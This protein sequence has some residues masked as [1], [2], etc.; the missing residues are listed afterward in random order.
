MNE[1]TDHLQANVV[2]M[3]FFECLF[4]PLIVQYLLTAYKNIIK[5]E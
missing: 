4:T 3:G 5:L 2:I 1:K